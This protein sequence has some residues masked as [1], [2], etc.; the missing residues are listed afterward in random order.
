MV[1]PASTGDERRRCLHRARVSAANL[2]RL[3]GSRRRGRRRRVSADVR[4]AG[5]LE[6]RIG[7]CDD[8]S[9]LA[10]IVR[11]AGGT[12]TPPSAARRLT[13]QSTAIISQMIGSTNS[14]SNHQGLP[15]TDSMDRAAIPA[16]TTSQTVSVGNGAS[17]DC[18][19]TPARSSLLR[20]QRPPRPSTAASS[21]RCQRRIRGSARR[22][23]RALH[24]PRWGASVLA[25]VAGL[26]YDAARSQRARPDVTARRAALRSPG[27]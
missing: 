11:R 9:P 5:Q 7:G 8:G 6:R 20:A 23:G 12:A 22:S 27:R 19:P 1:L 16:P 24:R 18:R 14:S 2:R 13:H 4:C 15:V 26:A 25:H 3:H 17:A 10:P 21:S